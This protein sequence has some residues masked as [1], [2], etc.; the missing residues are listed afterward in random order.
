MVDDISAGVRERNDN[1]DLTMGNG[2]L[3]ALNVLM[4]TPGEGEGLVE[5][6]PQE[7][8]KPYDVGL[9]SDMVKRSAPNDGLDLHHIPQGKPASQLIERYDYK[10]APAIALPES[11]HAAIPNMKGSNTAGTARQQLAR[12]MFNLKKYTNTPNSAIEKA[13]NINKLLYPEAMEK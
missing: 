7:P 6:V 9:Y 8:V 3:A 2:T 4:V 11:E 13:I 1:G 12:K 5:G 10:N